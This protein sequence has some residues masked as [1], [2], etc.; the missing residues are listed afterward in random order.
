MND[1]VSGEPV[2]RVA[3]RTGVYADSVTLLQLSQAVNE[4]P[5]VQAALV[6]MATDLNLQLLAGMGFAPPPT[7]SAS[8]ARRRC[9]SRRRFA[10]GSARPLRD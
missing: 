3:V 7:G 2:D 5:G 1:P 10:R 6:A 4:A 8:A 9:T